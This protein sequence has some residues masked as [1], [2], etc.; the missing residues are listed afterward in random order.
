MEESVFAAAFLERI[1]REWRE[2]C[3]NLIK[4]SQFVCVLERNEKKY[5]K[6]CCDKRKLRGNEPGGGSADAIRD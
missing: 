5:E 3:K 6:K 2:A 1:A 4:L